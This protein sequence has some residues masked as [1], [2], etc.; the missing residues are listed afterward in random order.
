[1]AQARSARA[2]N[3]RGTTRVRN[4]QYGPRKGVSK[5]FIINISFSWNRVRKNTVLDLAGCT[6]EYS[7]LNWPIAACVL[8]K[9]YNNLSYNYIIIDI[10]PFLYWRTGTNSDS[11]LLLSVSWIRY[12]TSSA[13]YSRI[14]ALL[15]TTSNQNNIN[16]S[17]MESKFFETS[18][19][20]ENWFEKSGRLRNRE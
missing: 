15:I 2:I 8:S 10:A 12:L 4:L 14:K 16:M 7:R 5:I 11:L 20:N 13:S 18:Q 3:R 19:E 6:V 9:R 1:M 17:T